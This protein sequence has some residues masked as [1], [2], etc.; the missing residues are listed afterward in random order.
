MPADDASD[1]EAPADVRDRSGDATTLYTVTV[2]SPGSGRVQ[3]VQVSAR[4]AESAFPIACAWYP[5]LPL[6]GADVEVVAVEPAA[7]T[8]TERSAA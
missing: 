5:L 3:Q 6:T 4:S 1:L 8:P 2:T 7:P